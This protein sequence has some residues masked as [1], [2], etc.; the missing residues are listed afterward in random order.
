MNHVRAVAPPCPQLGFNL[1]LDDVLRDCEAALAAFI[2]GSAV[3]ANPAVDR[4]LAMDAV[5]NSEQH[6]LARSPLP[7]ALLACFERCPQL[8]SLV[9]AKQLHRRLRSEDAAH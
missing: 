7:S 9:V 3:R 6:V 5:E 4:H 1:R 2:P 8:A